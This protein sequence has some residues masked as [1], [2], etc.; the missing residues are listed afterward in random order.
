M[1][2]QNSSK[3]LFVLFGKVRDETISADELAE[4][5]AKLLSD[6]A[7]LKAYRRFMTLCSG[8]EQVARMEID[9]ATDSTLDSPDDGDDTSRFNWADDWIPSEIDNQFLVAQQARELVT[10][11]ERSDRNQ[12]PIAR[13]RIQPYKIIVAATSIAALLLFALA[14]FYRPGNEEVLASIVEVHQAV[15]ED[16]QSFDDDDAMVAGS[17]SLVSGAV[18]LRYENKAELLVQAPSVFALDNAM[19]ATLLAG[20]LSLYV[21]PTATGFRVTTPQATVVDRGTRIGIFVSEER[22][23]EVHVF[24]G[25]AQTI[26]KGTSK[27]QMLD[28]GEAVMVARAGNEWKRM[29]ATRRHFAKS[30]TELNDMPRVAGDIE[31][32]VS[33]PRSVRRI[34]SELVDV[35][36]AVVFAEQDSIE[37]IE[38][39]PVTFAEPGK[40]TTL[41]SNEDELPTGV[42]VN[43]FFVHLAVPKAVRRTDQ[44]VIA[45]G[46]LKFKRP[47]QAI[48]SAE[49]GKMPD[50]FRCPETVY[51]GDKRTGLEDTIEHQ[52]DFA[53][54]LTISEDRMTL[55]FRLHVHG[56]EAAEQEDFIDQFRILVESA[57]TH[58]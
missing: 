58:E 20:S 49:P 2:D 41:E 7:A 9:A 53:D 1:K 27:K 12:D 29:R 4:L 44:S 5:E 6:S 37:L 36:R 23:M 51:P 43:T 52:P 31:L 32:R 19:Q 18:R 28:A 39:L 30:I 17:Y 25:K 40:P 48:V 14:S 42:R 56:R 47:I 16:K 21:P 54:M 13:E 15:W 35:G 26:L 55:T 33:P 57:T 3:E 50:A 24:E 46:T 22:G 34:D 45:A 10:T 8:L 38:P 11:V